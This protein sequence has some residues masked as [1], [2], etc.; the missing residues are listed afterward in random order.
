MRITNAIVT[1]FLLGQ[2]AA[3]CDAPYYAGTETDR[4]STS[5]GADIDDVWVEAPRADLPEHCST[6]G[7]GEG[8]PPPE[9]AAAEKDSI[10]GRSGET[11]LPS[12][13]GEVTVSYVVRDG[14]AIYGGDVDLGPVDADGLLLAPRGGT[15][16][17][18][19]WVW[20]DGQVVYKIDDALKLSINNKPS[21][22]STIA[23][24]VDYL[25][26]HTP[27]R[28]KERTTETDFVRFYQG[29]P[30]QTNHSDSIGRKGGQQNI[31]LTNPVG[32]GTVVHE[33]GHA[34]GLFHEQQRSDRDGYVQFHPEC[35][36]DHYEGNFTKQSGVSLEPYDFSSVMH[37]SPYG[38]C[39]D[40][41]LDNEYELF[42]VIG[43]DELCPSLTKVSDG[44][45]AN[46]SALPPGEK[47][48]A[49]DI[50][51]LVRIYQP[52]S[53]ADETGDAYGRSLAAGDFDNDGYDDLAVG[54]P[55]ES[56]GSDAATG[57][58][59]LLKG[60]DS[61]KLR[62]RINMDQGVGLKN[63]DG[64]GFGRVLAAGDFDGDGYDDV[65]IGTP[66]EDVNANTDFGSVYFAYGGYGSL[67]PPDLGLGL[68]QF[69]PGVPACTH[70]GAALAVEDFDADGDDDIV[71]ACDGTDLHVFAGS[72]DKT[73]MYAKTVI[74]PA[75]IEFDDIA[76]PVLHAADLNMD[77]KHDLVVGSPLTSQVFVFR[78]DTTFGKIQFS[79]AKTLTG[80]PDE[81]FGASV[82]VGDFN[83]DKV[84][85]LVVG[86][87]HAGLNGKL[88]SG[89]VRIYSG[90]K[91]LN[92]SSFNDYSPEKFGSISES[93]DHFG[94]TLATFRMWTNQTWLVVGSPGEDLTI[95]G[96][97]LPDVGCAHLGNLSSQ[98]FYMLFES[99]WDYTKNVAGVENVLVKA[100]LDPAGTQL[101]PQS[102]AA[103]GS[104][105]AV[106]TGKDGKVH[107]AIG[108]PGE[109]GGRVVDFR[110]DFRALP[111]QSTV[112]SY[113][114]RQGTSWSAA[115]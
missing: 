28:F 80:G 84:N 91:T 38:F 106:R 83:L 34:V 77:A 9:L 12:A 25:Q 54:V 67:G 33:I 50:N 26:R 29:A 103:F 92:L 57:R 20:P 79:L 49:H 31:R 87:P 114:Y 45:P 89:L 19:A 15:P 66:R 60:V 93:F 71:I 21:A 41:D 37:Y 69:P 55:G 105:I 97:H 3:A 36:H 73:L 95:N 115:N 86:R 7:Y 85:D 43:C 99:P 44:M 62:T 75:E 11:T 98:R 40:P 42:E 88:E 72:A 112:M 108:A 23:T 110:L 82:A 14:H 65:A 1:T 6:C 104:S 64:D 10:E 4:L 101:S 51:T 74:L 70:F 96:T 16:G 53:A 109:V 56:I 2:A 102:H 46:K 39:I 111:Q 27:L 8:Q 107:V 30:G 90:T 47:M 13:T 68:A 78:N 32:I 18:S 59:F 76:A 5:G 52:S 35:V 63:E 22:A 48:S 113:R 24:A 81:R 94:A 17:G 100:V 58:V 61:T